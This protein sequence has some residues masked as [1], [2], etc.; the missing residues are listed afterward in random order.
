MDADG[1]GAMAKR[2]A[3]MPVQY[4]HTC[5]RLRLGHG[6]RGFIRDGA[7]VLIALAIGRGLPVEWG[8]TT[9]SC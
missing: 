6:T 8:S 7:L 2:S 4:E 1:L 5:P 3:V 9:R